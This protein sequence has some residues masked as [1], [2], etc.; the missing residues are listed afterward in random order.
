M[1]HSNELCRRNIFL[2]YLPGDLKAEYF[3][4]VRKCS[5][6][7]ALH[8]PLITVEDVLRAYF[9]LADYFTDD[10]SGAQ[11]ESM[12]VG[13]RSEE[14]LA[15]ALSRQIV[16]F[17]GKTKYSNP[18]DICSTLFFGL[19]KNHAFLD[20]NKRVSLLI[21]LYQLFLFGY[22]PNVPE[23]EFEKLV[24]SVAANKI[25]RGVLKKFMTDKLIADKEVHAISYLLRRMVKK[26]DSSY[27]IAAT[28]KAFCDALAK[29]NVSAELD[30]GK[31]KFRRQIKKSWPFKDEIVS[32]SIVFGGWSR[33]IGAKTA[34][35]ILQNLKLYDQ[36]PSYQDFL[37]GS[38]PLYQMIQQFE[39]PLR[40]LKDE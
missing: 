25:D 21:L 14:L 20:G 5:T 4:L 33:V 28:A 9:I 22:I 19:V 23:K 13:L 7:E 40:R 39:G 3:R 17:D 36:Y 11:K 15:S 26:K 6:I 10:S 16:S 35:E 31:L 1:I 8:H 38:E 18:I 37:N 34:R 24:V 30:N 2:K 27:H 32:Y 29:A 12:L